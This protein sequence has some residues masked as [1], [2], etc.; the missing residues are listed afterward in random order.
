MKKLISAGLI[1]LVFSIYSTRVFAQQSYD[2]WV[3]QNSSQYEEFR[4]AMLSGVAADTNEFAAF[5]ELYYQE[6]E[7]FKTEIFTGNF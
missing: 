2:E 5:K 6:Y 1:G 3:Q 7:A 4:N